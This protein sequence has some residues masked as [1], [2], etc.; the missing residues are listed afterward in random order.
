M[1]DEF[2]PETR[3]ANTVINDTFSSTGT[4]SWDKSFSTPK[5]QPAYKITLKNTGTSNITVFIKKGSSNGDIQTSFTVK[6]GKTG[7]STMITD[8]A[9]NS[10]GTRYVVITS[11]GQNAYKGETKVVIA[12]YYSEL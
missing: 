8:N 1:Q 12:G 6:P 7:S 4:G 11:K 3:S 2:A 5:S 10:Q 9:G